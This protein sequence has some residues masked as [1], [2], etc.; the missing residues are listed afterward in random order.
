MFEKLLG[1]FQRA[2]WV[3][4]AHPELKQAFPLLE[5]SLFPTTPPPSAYTLPMG[6]LPFHSAAHLHSA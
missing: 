4:S 2:A 3:E 6:P 5:D 1:L